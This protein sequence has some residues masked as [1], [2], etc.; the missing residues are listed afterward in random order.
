MKIIDVAQNSPEWLLARAGLP[1]SSAF[2][3]IITPAQMKPSASSEAYMYQLVTESLL[4][5]PLETQTNDY[6]ARGHDLEDEAV[7]FFEGLTDLDTEKVGFCT[8]DDGLIG[9]SPDRLVG[10]NAGL[11]VK[12]PM[13]ATHVMYKDMG[14]L[15]VKYRA[16]V[17]GSLYVTGRDHWH[18]MSY[19]PILEPLHIIVERDSEFMEKFDILIK[20]FLVSLEA[21]KIRLGIAA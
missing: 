4:G 2:D 1:T 3:K 15:P 14:I 21:A 9:C 10:D 11:E 17:Q 19:N 13:A 7:L 6:M 16:Q 18:F 8:T 5:G 20:K 12:C